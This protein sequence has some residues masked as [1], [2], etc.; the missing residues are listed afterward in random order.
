M[1]EFIMKLRF[2][3]FPK[4]NALIGEISLRT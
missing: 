1:I 2:D 3:Q 4:S